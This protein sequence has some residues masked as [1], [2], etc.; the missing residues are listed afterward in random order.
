M[1]SKTSSMNIVKFHR[2][3]I[4]SLLGCVL[5]AGCS[6]NGSATNTDNTP[7]DKADVDKQIAA[8]QNDPKMQ[9]AEKAARVKALQAVPTK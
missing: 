2:L 8:I 3:L 6:G 5:I 9:P 7:A 1:L 4:G